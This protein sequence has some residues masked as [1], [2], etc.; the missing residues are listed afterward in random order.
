MGHVMGA[1]SV[2]NVIDVLDNIDTNSSSSDI[3][4]AADLAREE[5]KVS[6]GAR[7]VNQIY[8]LVFE[9]VHR[10]SAGNAG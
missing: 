6:T 3:R 1:E 8:S 2:G 7:K 10:A 9:L 5:A 4:D